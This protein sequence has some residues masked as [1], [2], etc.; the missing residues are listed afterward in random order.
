[1]LSRCCMVM[2]EDKHTDLLTT[3]SHMYTHTHFT[4]KL[5][6]MVHNGHVTVALLSSI[7]ASEF[8]II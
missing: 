3:E 4:E 7:G 6:F 5:P 2:H 8:S 1:M